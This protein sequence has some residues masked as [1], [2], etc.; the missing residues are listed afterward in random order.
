MSELLNTLVDLKAFL[1]VLIV[2][3]VAPGVVVR[4]MSFAF[5]RDDPRRQEMRAEFYAVPRLSRP[6]WVAEQV[7][8]VIFE[9]LRDRAINVL[10]GRVIWRWHLGDGVESNRL[11]P[12]TF[13]IPSPEEKARIT[14]GSV[15][16]LMFHMRDGWGERMWVKVEKVTRKGY[17]GTLRN[18][19]VGIP[20]LDYGDKVKFGPDAII[21][22]DPDTILSDDRIIDGTSAP[23]PRALTGIPRHEGR[24]VRRRASRGPR[25]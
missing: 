14:E 8:V 4:L 22:V 18:S 5:H 2:F 11:H 15:V 13:W 3:G 16:K 19:P 1:L 20:R 17:V 23:L 9:G 7:E 12:D 10:A 25:R 24:A 6:L 21:D